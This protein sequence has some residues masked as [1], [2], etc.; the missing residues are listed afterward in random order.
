[1]TQS[2]A[3]F[4]LSAMFDPQVYAA[5]RAALVRELA[6]RGARVGLV[7]VPGNHE[8]PM[9]YP[10]NTYRFRQ[11][12]SFL[13]FFGLAEPDLAATLDLDSGTATL[14]CGELSQDDLVWTGPRP[15][16]AERARLCAADAHADTDRLASDLAA[17]TTAGRPILYLPPYRADTRAELA[18]LLGLP[19]EAVNGKASMDLIRAV[20]ALREIKDSGEVAQI[21]QAV[22][23][24]VAMHQ[25][26][27]R[28]A[29]PGVTEAELMALA[30]REALAGGGMPSFPPIATT[31]GDVLH[32]HGYGHTLE[33]GGL[34][35]LDAGAETGS[36]YAGDLTST[37]PV[38]AR[39]NERQRAVYEI[40]LAAGRAAS[41]L[42]RPGVPYRDAHLAAAGVIARGLADLGILKGNPDDAVARGAHA[43]FFPHGVGHQ[44]GLDVH[45]CEALGELN[46]GYA[47][48]ETKSAQFG[49]KSLRMAK[50]VKPGM[51]LTVEPGVYFIGGL[52]A[53]WKAEGRFADCIDYEEA[54]R[55]V[56][57][58]GV[59]NEE[60]WLVTESGARKLG[61][62][63]DKS[64]GA[65]ESLRS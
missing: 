5:R 57:F 29:R 11:D 40:V 64:I 50:P 4:T 28:A 10:D 17:A 43:L 45:D 34:F 58:G 26:V 59:R 16:R 3:G 42:I 9:N 62:D 46:V 36:G 37:F 21:D 56:G 7:V 53:A 38:D 13:Y 51:V 33:S 8:A 12:S 44:M 41:S 31:R 1:M 23:R 54:E 39:Y 65:M 52:I 2:G 35:L 49:L 15:N 18:S 48:G 32:N 27:I 6:E 19:L 60:D 55:W 30:Y 47:E 24:S 22:D 61:G 20:I 63:F 14:Y 25:A